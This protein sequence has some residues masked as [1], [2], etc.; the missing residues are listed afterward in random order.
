MLNKL[1]KLTDEYA[2]TRNKLDELSNEIDK[3]M[4]LEVYCNN[5]KCYPIRY[6]IDV[7]TVTLY[8][9]DGNSLLSNSGKYMDISFDDF[10]VLLQLYNKNKVI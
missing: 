5:V 8:P 6:D 10:E 2:I 9:S 1:K 7:E 3:I 4:E